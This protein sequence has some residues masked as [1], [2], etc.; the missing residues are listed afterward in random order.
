MCWFRETVEWDTVIN[1]NFSVL[2][3]FI[4]KEAGISYCKIDKN[5]LLNMFDGLTAQ[6]TNKHY[7]NYKSDN[8]SALYED[9][10]KHTGDVFLDLFPDIEMEAK[11]FVSQK[12]HEKTSEF[13]G[14]FFKDIFVLTRLNC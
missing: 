10:R 7:P 1:R 11:I 4:L 5:T 6:Q 3:F 14:D 13:T 9:G 12:A 8:Y 2:L